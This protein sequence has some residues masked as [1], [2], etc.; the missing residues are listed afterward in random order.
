MDFHVGAYSA[1]LDVSCVILSALSV[2]VVIDIRHENVLQ[3]KTIGIFRDFI[4]VH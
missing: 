1:M 3:E 2:L 4:V